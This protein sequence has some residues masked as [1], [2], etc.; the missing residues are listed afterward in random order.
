MGAYLEY[1]DYFKDTKDK[2]VEIMVHPTYHE[3]KIVD[4]IYDHENEE[5][6]DFS[7]IR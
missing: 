7:K 4:I 2:T 3:G 1:V 5:Y 6:F